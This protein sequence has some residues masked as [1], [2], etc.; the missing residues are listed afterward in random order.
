MKL[1]NIKKELLKFVNKKAIILAIIVWAILNFSGI[2]NGTLESEVFLITVCFKIIHL[3]FLYFLFLII[4][5]IYNNKNSKNFKIGLVYFFGYLFIA[6]ILLLLIWPGAWS[7]DDINVLLRANFYMGTAWQHIFT[8]I[9]YVLFLQTVPI[10]SGILIMQILI[11]GAIIGYCVSKVSSILSNS[12]K[13]QKIISIILFIPMILPPIL[14]HI[15][16]GF[17]MGLYSYFELL[18]I[19]EMFVIY[20]E[21]KELNLFRIILLSLL[22]IFVASWRTE[23]IYYPIIF[24]LFLLLNRSAVPKRKTIL[25]IL[26]FTLIPTLMIGKLNNLLIG[27]NDYSI[28]ATVEPVEKLIKHANL[29]DSED[30][31]NINEVLDVN[32]ILNHPTWRGSQ[33]FWGGALREEYSESDYKNYLKSY[34]HLSLKYPYI[35]FK[36]MWDVFYETSGLSINRDGIT[37]QATLMGATLKIF[38][39]SNQYGDAWSKVK[40]PLKGPINSN[41]RDKTLRALACFDKN[42]AVLPPYYIFWNLFIPIILLFISF[43][44]MLFK[45]N[46]NMVFIILSL[47]VRIPLVFLTSSTS[48]FMYYL[49]FYVCAYF[50]SFVVFIELIISKN[51]NIKNRVDGIT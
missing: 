20:K 15:L 8:P 35:T 43:L 1:K 25:L 11:A 39:T 45:K 14:L 17:R 2:Q 23:A 3:F 40:S 38:D 42:S 18:L 24:S 21:K 7:W 6:L 30:L 36:A 26:I 22:V 10:A 47:F 32:F 50:I 41:L 34:L 19:T 9:L 44:I 51:K 27:T 29:E 28:T 46:W 31:N 16:S 48:L 5:N 4:V 49:S 12:I 13:T 37:N 33:Y